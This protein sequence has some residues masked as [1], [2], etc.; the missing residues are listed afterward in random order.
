MITASPIENR[1]GSVIVHVSDVRRAAEWY[2]KLLGLPLNERQLDGG[3]VYFFDLPGTGLLL[4]N[5]QNNRK[6]PDWREDMKPLFMYP[7]SDID[8]AYAYVGSRTEVLSEPNRHPGMAYFNFR[9][10]EG[11]VFMACWSRGGTVDGPTPETESPVLARIGGVFVNVR[12][13]RSMAVWHSGLLGLPLQ[14]GE[15]EKSVLSLRVAYGAS[16]LL[17]DNRY[18]QGDDYEVLFMFDT[19]DIGAAER[20]VTGLGIPL[21]GKREE[22]GDVS[23]FTI[24]DPDGNVIMVCQSHNPSEK[25]EV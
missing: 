4:D 8:E 15:T 24:R 2:C 22:H 18:R 6:N 21:F 16:L 7:C 10:P 25:A 11:R 5:N 12:E 14:A 17:Y 9:D 20:Y 13:M 1:I 3:S 19:R 23:F